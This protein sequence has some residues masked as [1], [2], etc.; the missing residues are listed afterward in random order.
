MFYVNNQ[1]PESF[2]VVFIILY[3]THPLVLPDTCS[4]SWG[5]IENWFL[6]SGDTKVYESS[7]R[8]CNMVIYPSE[9]SLDYIYLIK[10]KYH[11]NYCMLDCLGSHDKKQVYICSTDEIFEFFGGDTFSYSFLNSMDME[12]IDLVAYC[13]HMHVC[14]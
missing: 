1:D 9:L 8:M 13:I 11:V 12:S 7:N 6:I 14:I 4:C 2:I 3:C 5:S 10:C